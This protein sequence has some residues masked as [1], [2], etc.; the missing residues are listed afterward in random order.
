MGCSASRRTRAAGGSLL[1]IK[2]Y[3][4][5][6]LG[7]GPRSSW[8]RIEIAES[9]AVEEQ[10][11]VADLTFSAR[12]DGDRYGTGD[13]ALLRLTLWIA[14]EEASGGDADLEAGEGV[15]YRPVSND[16]NTAEWEGIASVSFSASNDADKFYAKLSTR[17][18]PDIYG[19]YGDPADADLYFETSP[20]R[21]RPTPP[22]ATLIL[23]NPWEDEDHQPDPPG[24]ISTSWRRT[25]PSATSPASSPISTVRTATR[26][27]AGA[28]APTL[29]CYII[30]DVA[31]DVSVV[32]DRRPKRPRSAEREPEGHPE[33]RPGE[34]SRSS[35][36]TL[37]ALMQ[38]E[39]GRLP[40]APPVPEEK[41]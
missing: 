40:D 6:S 22:R 17:I 28:P 15:V 39:R 24:A 29:G 18:D 13:Y 34:L 12:K 32:P 23:Y 20:A 11:A 35:P 36:G 38:T 41:K 14:S 16:K 21:S 19:L 5:K 1:K 33:H 37:K 25:E 26:S 3:G 30:S 7:N 9:E 31:L 8:L 2:Q 4:E 10:K 27:T